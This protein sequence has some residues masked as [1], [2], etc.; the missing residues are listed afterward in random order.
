MEDYTDRFAGI[1]FLGGIGRRCVIWIAHWATF[2]KF[3]KRKMQIGEKKEISFIYNGEKITKNVEIESI[4]KQGDFLYHYLDINE[5]SDDLDPEFELFTIYNSLGNEITHRAYCKKN[6]KFDDHGNLINVVLGDKYRIFCEYKNDL[7]ITCRFGKRVAYFFNYDSDNRISE[8]TVETT[9]KDGFVEK[10]NHKFEYKVFYSN[11]LIVNETIT[12]IS[13]DKPLVLEK[14]Q[15]SKTPGH[16][17]KK[18]VDSKNKE[19]YSEIIIEKDATSFI[20]QKSITAVTR[21]KRSLKYYCEVEQQL[22]GYYSLREVI[23]SDDNKI[24]LIKEIHTNPDKSKTEEEK[25]VICDGEQTV[26]CNV[27][28]KFYIHSDFCMN[29]E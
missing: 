22:N 9:G 21:K 13:G 24:Q 29:I 18:I 26:F 15:Y 3:R 27:T 17:I 25:I 19:I 12:D 6:A 5:E 16:C 14:Y 7:L 10:V 2:K 1:R 28:D 8:Y 4:I 23:V 11:Q 20:E